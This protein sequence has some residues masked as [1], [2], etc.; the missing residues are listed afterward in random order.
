MSADPPLL[1]LRNVCKTY[2]SGP[3]EV[4]ALRDVSVRVLRGELTALVGP[5]GSGKS[6]LLHL[7]GCLDSPTSGQ[8]FLDGVD[9]GT[10]DDAGLA[11]VR[12]RKIGFVF[13]SFNLLPRLTAEQNV[14]LPLQYRGLSRA[15][16]LRQ[17][18]A[19][20][21]SVQLLPR[22]RHRPSELSGGER[23]RVAIAR[24]LITSPSILLADEPTGNLDSRVGGEILNLFDSLNSQTGVTVLIVTHDMSVAQRCRRR[25]L[26]RDGCLT[27]DPA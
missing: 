6:T 16:R 27:E 17:A 13:Q 4:H 24:A 21:E 23:Q 11:E 26:V 8:Y 18:R 14:Q 10:L 1:E 7:I 5:S 15:E 9:T 25:L 12:N 20:L 3:I 2:R 22:A 19:A